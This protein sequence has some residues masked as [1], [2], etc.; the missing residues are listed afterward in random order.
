MKHLI[1]FTLTLTSAF[2]EI[3]IKSGEKIAFLGDSIT[4]QGKGN[5][6]GY[7]N[8][9]NSGLAAHGVNVEVIGA[10]ISGHKSN[11][12]L[13]RLE[14][15]VLTHKPQWMTLSCGVNDV[16]HGANGVLIDDYKKNITAIVDQAQAA[17]IKVILLT[18]TMIGE[19]QANPN[20]QKLI[21]YNEFLRTLAKEKNC[22]L[23]DL[24]A[25]MQADVLKANTPGKNA[26]TSDG[27]HMALP[28]NIMMANG[29][30]QALGLD[31]KQLDKANDAWLDLPAT[32][33]LRF[34]AKFSLREMQQLEKAAAA[35]NST[36]QKLL[37]AEF[38]K[39]INSLK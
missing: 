7:V 25:R 24:N 36:P 18:P 8:L 5:P 15:D 12:M 32:A 35:R 22:L 14:K 11:Q 27:V 38:Q 34:E 39:A 20:N 31:A 6:A 23:A 4:Q 13:A 19:D 2:A 33:A 21:P 16:W 3:S 10:G 9:V 1:L 30:L 17:G 28:G 37:E 29:V 26:L